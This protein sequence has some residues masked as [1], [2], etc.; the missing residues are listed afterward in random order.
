MA[1]VYDRHS[2]FLNNLYTFQCSVSAVYFDC[3]YS[4]TRLKGYFTSWFHKSL[5]STV[6]DLQ[7]LEIK[8]NLKRSH[9]I[10]FT[11]LE[12]N[13]CPLLEPEYF[14][15]L[16]EWIHCWNLTA[17]VLGSPSHCHRKGEM[18]LSPS[19]VVLYVTLLDH[20]FTLHTISTAKSTVGCLANAKREHINTWAISASICDTPNLNRSED[21]GF[22]IG[23]LCILVFS[24]FV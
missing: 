6:N 19:K 4:K 21:I 16:L 13:A 24:Y 2:Y 8:K 14:K 18:F 15:L 23:F 9:L 7:I 10:T 22:L 11:P 3:R 20:V 17:L 1:F 12:Q 5:N